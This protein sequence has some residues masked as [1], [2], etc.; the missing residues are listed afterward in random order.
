MDDEKGG[1]DGVLPDHP[2]EQAW[3]TLPHENIG[4][5]EEVAEVAVSERVLAGRGDVGEDFGGVFGQV[6]ARQVVGLGYDSVG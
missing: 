6:L 4:V 1:H 2:I 5:R 3:Q